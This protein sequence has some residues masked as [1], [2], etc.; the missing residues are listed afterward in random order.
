MKGKNVLTNVKKK[1]K[2]KKLKRQ[3]D[4]PPETKLVFLG[5]IIQKNKKHIHK[6]VIDTNARL[7]DFCSQKEH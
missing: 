4:V 2:Q 7:E 1:T 6:D 3:T 5:L